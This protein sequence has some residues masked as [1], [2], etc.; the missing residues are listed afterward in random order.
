MKIGI[1]R[2]R[3]IGSRRV[4]VVDDNE[5]LRAAIQFMLRDGYE[6]H[7]MVS[8]TSA[9][10]V[11]KQIKPDLLVLAEGVIR[12][13]GPDLIQEFLARAPE[14]KI[15]IVVDQVSS[16]FG[17]ICIAAG[18]HD[19]LAKPPR[20]ELVRDKVEALLGAKKKAADASL[21]VANMG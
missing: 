5:N 9:L 6:A 8:A 4:F 17:Q 21:K 3:V 16:G 15:L 1:E 11:A 2:A 18:A 20:A 14:A 19:F 13:N 12:V 10:T 7:E